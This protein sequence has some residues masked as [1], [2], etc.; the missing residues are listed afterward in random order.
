MKDFLDFHVMMKH[1]S[2]YIFPLLHLKTIAYRC[3]HQTLFEEF[4]F[5]G[6]LLKGDY[7][8]HDYN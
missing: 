3:P 8:E 6:I 2:K 4:L 7:Y 1:N 5:C